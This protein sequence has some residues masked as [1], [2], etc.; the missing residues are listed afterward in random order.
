MIRDAARFVKLEELEDYQP[1][2]RMR[3]DRPEM[4][5]DNSR[6]IIKTEV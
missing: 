2:K 4:Q 5:F 1:K 6:I 3:R